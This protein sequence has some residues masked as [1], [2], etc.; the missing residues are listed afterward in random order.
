MDKTGR[1]EL[2]LLMP[3][4]AQKHVTHNE[5]LTLL[6]TLVHPA[7]KTFGNSAPPPGVQ[8]DDAFFVGPSATG[9]WFGQSGKIAVFTD[10]G[11]RFIAVQEGMTALD[12]NNSQYVMFNGLAWEPLADHLA[13]SSLPNLGINT[14]ADN[15]N[16]LTVR[17]NAALLNAIDSAGGGTGDIRLTLN[18]EAIADT[19]SLVFQTGFSGRAEFGLTGDDDF[20]VKVSPN[21]SSWNEAI[22][23]S[24]TTGLVT[25]AAN[26]V[27]NAALA[28]MASG[29]F[30]GRTSAGNGD[31]QDMTPAQA[32]ALLD[33][34]TT[35]AKGLA[36]ASGGGTANFLRADGA[37]AVPSGGGSFNPLDLTATGVAAPAAGTVRAFRKDQC[38]R[39]ML[40]FVGPTGMDATVQPFLA[41]NKIARWNAMGNTVT[42]PI[43]DGFAAAFTALGTGT[44]RLVAATNF[45]TRLRRLGYVSAA[46]AGALCGHYATVAQWTIGTGTGL[47]G[48][49][50]LC[51]FVPSDATLVAGARMFVGLRNSVAA[52]A[53][54]EP[55]SGQ[56]NMIGVAQIST[57]NNL[58][59]VY[60]GSAAQAPIDLGAGFPANGASTAAY[61]LQLFASPGNQTVGYKVTRMDTGDM[62]AGTLSGTAGTQ[63]PAASTFL[64]HTAWRCNNAAALACGLDM[65]QVYLET[66]N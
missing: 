10:M 22:T 36:P 40:A 27:A 38:G 58:H 13:I 9:D 33:V 62:A 26:S 43:N 20:H 66:D 11:W 54:I 2:P 57:S 24:K 19:G 65:V 21:G 39:Q 59:I 29:T 16:K 60:G 61:E 28:D 46:T 34:F 3:S 18:K 51:R 12:R 23:V 63:L 42:V 64:G 49:H 1:Y 52:P 4:Q 14:P 37:W 55:S 7:I 25:L 15:G 5:A 50:Y 48:F 32:T 6:D 35:G 41:T 44:A 31:P 53:N 45:I 8:V 56:I 47:G 17:S 30:K